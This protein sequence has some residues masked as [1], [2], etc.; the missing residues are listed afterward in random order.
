L[1]HA[2]LLVEDDDAAFRHEAFD[3]RLQLS[4]LQWVASSTAGATGL[5]EN[6][7]GLPVAVTDAAE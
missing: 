2:L 6:Y 4:Q 1:L 5:A 7:A 3:N